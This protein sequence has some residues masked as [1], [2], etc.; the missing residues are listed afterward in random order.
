MKPADA[1]T[2]GDRPGQGVSRP[3]VAGFHRAVRTPPTGEAFR[4]QDD[5]TPE[6][7]VSSVVLLFVG[8][9]VC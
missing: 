3:P 5:P 2:G 4:Y 1:S 6:A 8:D 9:G 7:G